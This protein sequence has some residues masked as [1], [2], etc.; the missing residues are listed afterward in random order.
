MVQAETCANRAQ[1]V[2]A[3]VP[4]PD[5]RIDTIADLTREITSF[6]FEDNEE[7][8]AATAVS[9]HDRRPRFV[10]RPL[11]REGIE[12]VARLTRVNQVVTPRHPG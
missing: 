4:H 7:E 9:A 6:V 12:I 11:F 5:R 2:Q 8:F 3:S 1:H 10:D